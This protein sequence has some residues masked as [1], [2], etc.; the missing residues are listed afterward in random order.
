MNDVDVPDDQVTRRV[1]WAMPTGL[2]V[3]GSVGVFGH[4]P[5]NLM[6]I[7]LVTQVATDPRIIALGIERDSVTASLVEQSGE[8]ALSLLAREDRAVVRSFVRP[9]EDII[10]GPDGIRYYP[11]EF[12]KLLSLNPALQSRP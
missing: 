8:M 1:L 12:E 6:T 2:Y 4:G 3:L 5:W 10:T 7:N 9:V 11:A